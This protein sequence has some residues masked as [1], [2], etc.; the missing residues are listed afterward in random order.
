MLDHDY[1][2]VLVQQQSVSS[3]KTSIFRLFSV[4][5]FHYFFVAFSYSA[6]LSIFY[7]GHSRQT[8]TYN[9]TGIKMD[10]SVAVL[11]AVVS[12]KCVLLVIGGAHGAGRS[13]DR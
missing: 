5:S 9:F 13:R 2:E 8:G 1:Q 7:E 4:S 3:Q 10:A 6:L 12:G 11:H